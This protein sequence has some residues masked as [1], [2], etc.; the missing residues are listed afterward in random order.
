MEVD[1]S[2]HNIE[3][4]Y[5]SLSEMRKTI[6]K[7]SAVSS[8]IAEDIRDMTDREYAARAMEISTVE[9]SKDPT[10]WTT[11]EDVPYKVEVE[12]HGPN[13]RVVGTL[14]ASWLEFGTGVKKNAN[15]NHPFLMAPYGSYGKGRGATGH[16]WVY[17]KGK[18]SYGYQATLGMYN[19]TE[20]VRSH[21]NQYTDRLFR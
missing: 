9:E 13:A 10:K 3:R 4:L 2:V 20:Y 18:R 1:I 8:A 5:D 14:G 19:A 7:A 11:I 15:S 16:S 12:M 6:S 21:I 17:A